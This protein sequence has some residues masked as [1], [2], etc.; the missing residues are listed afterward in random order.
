VV[1]VV[2]VGHRAG[3]EPLDRIPVRR[4]DELTFVAV[5]DIASIVAEGELLRNRL[6]KL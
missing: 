3:P 6:F 1:T 5:E 4:R 2:L